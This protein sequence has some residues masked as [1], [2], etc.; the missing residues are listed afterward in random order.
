MSHPHLHFEC[1][2]LLH[3]LDDHDEEGQFDAQGLLGVGGT[4]NVGCGHVCPE[5][6][7]HQALDFAVCNTLDVA[8]ADLEREQEGVT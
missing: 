1:E 4:S 7:Q 2:V 8:I 6:L 3:V 5:D